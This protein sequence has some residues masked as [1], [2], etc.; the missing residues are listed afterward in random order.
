[1]LV[2]LVSTETPTYLQEVNFLAGAS[3]HIGVG[4]RRDSLEELE[5][6]TLGEDDAGVIPV[7]HA[8]ERDIHE[9]SADADGRG[10]THRA[11]R[12]SRAPWK[13]R[14]QWKE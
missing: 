12:T 10:R 11:G 7:E 2:K 3:R 8:Y 14:Q 4:G 1:M 13:D 5:K 6:G 9:R